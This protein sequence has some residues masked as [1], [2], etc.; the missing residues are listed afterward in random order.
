MRCLVTLGDSWMRSA[1][2]A[3]TPPMPMPLLLKS[4]IV[5]ISIMQWAHYNSHTHALAHTH[6]HTLTHTCACWCWHFGASIPSK[7]FDRKRQQSSSSSSSR[8]EAVGA[9]DR[10]GSGHSR[11]AWERRGER[12]GTL[13]NIS[14]IKH[15]NVAHFN[16]AQ[17]SMHVVCSMQ[18]SI[19]CASCRLWTTLTTL[20]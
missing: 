2:V 16:F 18:L 3:E 13:S 5:S 10:M 9:A 6:E 11:R 15:A 12:Q 7:R 14:L 20:G 8:R 19:T 4:K 17:V 1:H